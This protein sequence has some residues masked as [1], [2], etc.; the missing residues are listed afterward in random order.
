MLTLF[1]ELD[2]QVIISATLKEQELLANKYSSRNDLNAI[3]YGS[4]QENHILSPDYVAEFKTIMAN[5]GLAIGQSN[6]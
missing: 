3:D 2:C 6:V 1:K 4:F 5:F